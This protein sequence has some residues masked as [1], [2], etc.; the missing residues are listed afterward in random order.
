MI[1][2]IEKI[3][4]LKDRGII[5]SDEKTGIDE[6]IKLRA[7]VQRN[8]LSAKLMVDIIYRLSD[9]INKLFVQ[10]EECRQEVYNLNCKIKTLESKNKSKEK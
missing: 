6:E 2:S 9:E 4:L 10:I 1:D 8:Q 3:K 5:I 7:N